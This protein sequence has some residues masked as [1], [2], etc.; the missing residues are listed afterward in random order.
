MTRLDE[1]CEASAARDTETRDIVYN[2]INC[3]KPIV[4]A[5]ERVSVAVR[6]RGVR[7]MLRGVAIGDPDAD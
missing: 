6:R 7:R 3:R 5:S 4:S 1:S 2:I